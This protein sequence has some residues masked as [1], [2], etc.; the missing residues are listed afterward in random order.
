MSTHMRGV[1]W[2]TRHLTLPPGPTIP[3]FSPDFGSSTLSA[4]PDFESLAFPLSSLLGFLG[5]LVSLEALLVLSG[6][7]GAT[8]T[9]PLAET[10]MVAPVVVPVVVTLGE[11]AAGLDEAVAAVGLVGG[12][13]A[14]V[15]AVAGVG[16]EVAA[17]RLGS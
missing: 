5:F 12:A 4:F 2:M 6:S 1:A 11:A 10:A 9:E 15:A 7:V 3:D 16:T 13:G 14:V 17:R 8:L